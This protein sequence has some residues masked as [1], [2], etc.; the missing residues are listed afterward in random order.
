MVLSDLKAQAAKE[1]KE[2]VEEHVKT[3]TLTSD[4]PRKVGWT[5]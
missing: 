3:K 4:R 1:S 2:C 5:D